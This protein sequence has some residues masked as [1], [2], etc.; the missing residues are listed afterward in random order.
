LPVARHPGLFVP[1][2][3]LKQ[4]GQAEKVVEALALAEEEV[5]VG[6]VPP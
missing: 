6:S 4:K 3:I 1:V 5:V 2:V